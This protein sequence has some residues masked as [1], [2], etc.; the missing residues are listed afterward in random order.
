MAA[1]ELREDL[2]DLLR[3]CVQC[4]LCLPHC[5]TWLATGNEVQSPRGRLLLLGEVLDRADPER[6][7][8]EALDRCIGCRACETACPSGV[9]FTLLEHGQE[10]AR[11]VAPEPA[12]PGAVQ[13]RLD[14][15]VFLSVLR[16]L[17][18]GGRR[19]ARALGG[20]GWRDRLP[21]RGLSRA[22]GSVPRSPGSAAALVRELDRLTGLTGPWR[23]PQAASAA[24]EGEL[25]FFAGCVNRGLL[26]GTSR[27]VRGLLAASGFDVV[28]TSGQDCCGAVAAH[29]GRPGR[30][31]RL[32]RRNRSAFAD[33]GRI[34][35]E[36]AGCGLELDRHDDGAAGRFVDAVALLSGAPLPQL[37]TVPLA[38]AV[39]D[40]CHARHGRGIVAEPRILL[41]RVPGL[42]ILEPAEPEVC[43][44]SGGVWG[45]RHPRLSETLGRR[46]ARLLAATGADLIVTANP[47][48]LGQI[49]DGL[50]REGCQVPVLPLTDLVW[51]A[52]ARAVP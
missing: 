9:P 35:V 20:S 26:P 22:L 37:A 41:G 29:T 36:A 27:R 33:A 43:C 17:A 3:R 2:A 16:P 10:L 7:H 34:V 38:V 19:A 42:R 8:L 4:G 51:Y 52:A 11:A 46:K 50:A 44:G 1:A 25:A 23:A 32:R 40:P 49:A 21:W 13:R 48:C 14:D 39:H 24:T 12:L 45:L 30:A 5:A 28:F 15:P 31:A 6:A 18:T 47:G